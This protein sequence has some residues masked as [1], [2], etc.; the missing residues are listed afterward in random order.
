M[1]SAKLRSV[2]N[3]AFVSVLLCFFFFFSE[4]GAREVS[5]KRKKETEREREM[6]RE[7]DCLHTFAHLSLGIFYES[8]KRQV[9]GRVSILGTH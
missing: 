9:C 2:Y 8:E 4:V 7:R 5:Q 6:G 1:G 3:V